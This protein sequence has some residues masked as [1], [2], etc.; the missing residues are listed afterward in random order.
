MTCLETCILVVVIGITTL[1]V[2]CGVISKWFNELRVRTL[3]AGKVVDETFK[4]I[5]DVVNK[6]YD[7]ISKKE[8]EKEA[9]RRAEIKKE[10]DKYPVD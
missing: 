8:E 9:K 10:L 7:D 3:N 4:G 6:L 2:I 1:V 5:T